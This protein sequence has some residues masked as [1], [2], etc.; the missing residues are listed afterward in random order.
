M[1][2]SRKFGPKSPAHPGVGRPCPACS[3]PF[4]AGDFT[5][6]VMLGPGDDPEARRKAAAWLPYNAVAVEVHWACA[7][8][9]SG[10][11]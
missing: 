2:T 7:T 6:L 4:V 9:E 3:T 11:S 1:A 8:G 5:A 10:A